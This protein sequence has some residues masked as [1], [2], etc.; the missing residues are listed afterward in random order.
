MDFLPESISNE[1]SK[2][3]SIEVKCSVSGLVAKLNY[4][5]DACVCP[6]KKDEQTFW[7]VQ[8]MAPSSKI[9][10]KQE[11]TSCSLLP[12]MSESCSLVS[13]AILNNL[14]NYYKDCVG[15]R[16]KESIKKIKIPEMFASNQVKS[17]AL[18]PKK[19]EVHVGVPEIN[20]SNIPEINV[21]SEPKSEVQDTPVPIENKDKSPSDSF[22]ESINANKVNIATS[23]PNDKVDD[24]T[25]RDANVVQV[26][27]E[28]RSK[29]DQALLYMKFNVTQDLS[30]ASTTILMTSPQVKTGAR[31]LGTPGSLKRSATANE[32]TQHKASAQKVK[33]GSALSR[34]C[35]RIIIF[36]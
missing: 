15:E 10:V 31:T 11:A 22:I 30:I 17:D 26:L 12:E 33:Q 19:A 8:C 6:K 32:I 1:K 13:K 18:V 24:Q 14:L 34:K 29:I 7:E 23:S 28:A 5:L 35:D 4:K 36:F 20:I 9:Q 27:N 3:I 16:E 2:E 21:I 25:N